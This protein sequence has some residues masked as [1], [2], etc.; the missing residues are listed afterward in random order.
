MVS[1]LRRYVRLYLGFARYCLMREISFRVN[2]LVRCVT[3]I[4]WI[5]M[6]LM[7]FQLIFLNTKNIGDWNKHEYLFF[8]GTGFVLNAV[9]NALFLENCTN[10]S[11]LIRTGNLD[12]A[13]IKPVDEQFLLTCQRIDWSALP[14]LLVGAGLLVYSS[15]QAGVEITVPRVINFTLLLTAGVAILYSLMVAMAASSVWMIR[16]R[17][18]YEVWF[19]VNQFARYP[20]EIYRGNPLG[21]ALHFSLMFVVPILLAV[22][23][24]ARY[25]VHKLD[26]SWLVVYL[27]AAAAL[28]VVASRWFFRYALHHY[29]SASS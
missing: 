22:N 9:L 12:F 17:G 15:R 8:M 19:Y 24:P 18:L 14:N 3:S 11:E 26:Q 1:G 6:I 27:G 25:G 23:I 2:F 29:Q 13:L 5:L 28:S 4:F 10:L 20:A 16:N 7:F 21:I